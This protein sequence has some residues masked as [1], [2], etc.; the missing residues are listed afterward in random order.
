MPFEVRNLRARLADQQEA[1]RNAGW[2]SLF[3]CNHDQPRVVSRW[4]DDSDRE[5][6]ELS[7]K[8]FGMLLHMHRGTPYIYEGEELGMT[9]AHF[10]K[11]DQYRD[12]EAINAYR[13]R[14]EEARC[15]SPE[16]MMAAL[17]LIGRDNSRTPM[18][19]DASS[20]AGLHRGRRGDGTVDRRESEPCG[21]QRGR[22]VRRS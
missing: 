19:W 6:R 10:T 12:L 22:G 2:A 17:A 4:G 15:Q 18:Q 9:N 1:V 8:A 13:Q 7:A 5:S 11:L 16:S 21:D 14:V 3:F 20:Y